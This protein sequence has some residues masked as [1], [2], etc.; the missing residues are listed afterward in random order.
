VGA[1]DL[2]KEVF[3]QGYY[4]D[5]HKKYPNPL[6]F[7]KEALTGNF[8]IPCLIGKGKAPHYI[9]YDATR[10][11]LY[12]PYNQQFGTLE[13][14]DFTHKKIAEFLATLEIGS[15]CGF[16]QVWR[17]CTPKKKRRQRKKTRAGKK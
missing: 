13:A 10:G 15:I 7:F 8:V 2:K 14:G 1:L 11:T 16:H 4:L 5:I 3:R 9:A 17:K 6:E 12:E